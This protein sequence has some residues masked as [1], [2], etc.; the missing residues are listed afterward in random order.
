MIVLKLISKLIKALR[1]NATPVQLSWG[2]VLGMFPGLTPPWNAHNLLIAVLIIIL[3]VNISMAIL[4]FLFFSLFAYLL[5]PLFHELGYFLL[6]EVSFLESVW[7]FVSQAPVM[8]YFNLNNTVVLGSLLVC[9]LLIVPVFL[10]MKRFVVYYRERLEERIK[11][12]KIVQALM[13]SK[14]YSWFER[15]QK[16]GE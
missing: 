15:L 6:V 1:S 3:N 14:L 11:K 7:L 5:D 12:L 16:L 13:G 9:I 4:A 10:L 8:A 2:F